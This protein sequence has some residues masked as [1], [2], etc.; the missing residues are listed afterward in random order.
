MTPTSP[1]TGPPARW[2]ADPGA[3]RARLVHDL[4]TPMT[5]VTGFADILAR[6]DDLTAGQRT[7][8]LGRIADAATELRTI[9]DSE[10]A[11]RRA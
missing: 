2:P 9:L 11:D 8:Y 5:I 1:E 4:R 3:R 7:E 10:A 6:R